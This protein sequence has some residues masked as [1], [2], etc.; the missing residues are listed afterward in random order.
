MN[1]QYIKGLMTIPVSLKCIIRVSLHLSSETSF[2]YLAIVITI[3]HLKMT[4]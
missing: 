2:V 1:L 4:G 3:Y